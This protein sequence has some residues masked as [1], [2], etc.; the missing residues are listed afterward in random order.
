LLEVIIAKRISDIKKVAADKRDAV[1]KVY[2]KGLI[3]GKSNGMYIQNRVFNGYDYMTTADAKKV[4][5]L[6]KNI[7]DRAKLSPDGQLIRTTNLPKNAKSYPYIL[8]A[9]PN[10]FYEMKFLYQI[11]TYSWDPVEGKDYA[12]AAYISK[13]IEKEASNSESIF[14]FRDEWVKKVEDNLKYRLN[15]DYR[16]INN[17]WVNNLRSTYFIYN[18]AAIDKKTT[19]DIKAYMKYI[20]KNQIVIKSSAIS[21]V[22]SSLYF[23]QSYR[24]RVY[25]KFKISYPGEKNKQDDMFFSRKHVNF[26]GLIRDKWFEGI[27]DIELATANGTSNG[28]DLEIFGDALDDYYYKGE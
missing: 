20:K 23:D 26:Q 9:F 28:S 19:D 6:L 24:I 14:Q 1:A 7:K 3:V 13:K 10:S 16:T 18:I 27:Y 12:S 5:G 4:V 11:R 21:V 8:E 22:P 15:V 17:T 25:V 2:A